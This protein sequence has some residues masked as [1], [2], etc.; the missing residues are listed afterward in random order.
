MLTTSYSDGTVE[1][2]DGWNLISI[3]KKLDPNYNYAGYVFG[4]VDTGGHSIYHFNTQTQFWEAMAYN[5]EVKQLQGYFVYS[6]GQSSLR[7]V[8]TYQ[9]NPSTTLYPGWNMIGFFDPMGNPADDYFHAAMARDEMA[10]LGG[11]WASIQGFNPITQQ[12]QTSIIN[13]GSDIHSDYRLMYP[14]K[15]YWIWMD[16]QHS[17]TFTV[18]HTYYHS[19]EYIVDYPPANPDRDCEPCDDE[20]I[21]FYNGLD[22]DTRWAGSSPGFIYG[23]DDANE[24]HWK[25]SDYGGQDYDYID[26]TH[27]AFFSGHGGS[28]GIEFSDGLSSTVLTYDESLWGNT[29][30]DWI[31]L[32]ACNVLNESSHQN[33]ESAFK[34]LHSIVGWDTISLAH[35]DFGWRFAYYLKQGD[36]SIWESWQRAANYCIWEQNKYKVAILAVDIDK[37]TN[38]RECIDDHIYGKGTWFSPPGYDPGFKY[39]SVLS[40]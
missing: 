20:A 10:Q 11:S 5:T 19:A 33:W 23:N 40:Y 7:T 25:D 35:D 31:A 28:T 26:E 15:G 3:P 21:D 13:G 1:L 38:T 27:F 34:G 30:V 24:N 39:E 14:G 4:D 37:N 8:Y 2:L 12:Y 9:T 18:D 36:Y 16:S 6:I 22:A 32:A 29:R 17:W